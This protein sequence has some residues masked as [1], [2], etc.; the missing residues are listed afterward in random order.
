MSC[1]GLRDLSCV[2]RVRLTEQHVVG[3]VRVERRFQVHQVGR[4]T[5]DALAQHVEVVAV[6]DLVVRHGAESARR[7]DVA[8]VGQARVGQAR[9]G[10]QPTNAGLAYG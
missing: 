7:G 3:T 1:K 2:L 4:F 8:R 10:H 6:L 9:V 5:L